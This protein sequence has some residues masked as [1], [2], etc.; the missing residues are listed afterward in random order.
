VPRLAPAASEAAWQPRVRTTA[1]TGT[2]ADLRGVYRVLTSETLER[3]DVRDWSLRAVG[4]RLVFAVSGP[5]DRQ[6]VLPL[7]ARL[8]EIVGAEVDAVVD[9][10]L[11]A[12]RPQIGTAGPPA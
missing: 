8:G 12:A 4:D 2:R 5:R 10:R 7:V 3:W 6:Q 1:G 11:A 9:P